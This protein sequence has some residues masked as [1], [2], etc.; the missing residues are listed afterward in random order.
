M[1]EHVLNMVWL[2]IAAGAFAF[3]LP[4]RRDVRVV[5]AVVFAVALLFPIISASDDLASIDSVFEKAIAVLAALALAFTFV[6]IANVHAEPRR[7][8][9]LLLVAESGTRA[10]PRR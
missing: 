10:P 6:V 4:R 5:A 1:I 9:S 3:V 7:V 8:A 2:T